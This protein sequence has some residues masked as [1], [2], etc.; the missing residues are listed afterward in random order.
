MIKRVLGFDPGLANTGW[1][2]VDADTSRFRIVSYGS[3]STPADMAQ[4]ERLAMIFSESEEIIGKYNP[5][6]CGI[7]SL[8]FAR[9]ITSAIP[10]AQARGILLLALFQKG[11]EAEEYTPQQIKLAVTGSGAAEKQQ[12]QEMIRILLG[13]KSVP[14]PD[15]AADAL[16]AAVCCY[17]SW[18]M[19]A[20]GVK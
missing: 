14:K 17:N 7:E 8:Y 3:I 13:L 5:E 10:V 18:L 15:H 12:M 9:N 11:I 4:G 2:V 16:G 6:L 1:G 19:R 20:R